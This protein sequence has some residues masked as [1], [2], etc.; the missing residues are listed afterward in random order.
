MPCDISQNLKELNY[1]KSP[2]VYSSKL[3]PIR[4][5]SDKSGNDAFAADWMEGLK[6]NLSVYV[7]AVT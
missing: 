6:D 4:E 2:S 3:R 1:N 7:Y 5:L